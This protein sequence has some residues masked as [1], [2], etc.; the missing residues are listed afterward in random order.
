MQHHSLNEIRY[1]QGANFH[2]GFV[3]DIIFPS[4][5]TQTVNRPCMSPGKVE[6]EVDFNLQL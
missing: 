4:P 2:C 6:L 1:E 5:D 3:S